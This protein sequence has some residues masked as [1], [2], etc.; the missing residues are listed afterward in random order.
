MKRIIFKFWLINILINIAL[1]ITYRIVISET[2]HADGNFL[3]TLLQILDIVLNLAYSFIYLIAITF[4]SFAL[5][6]NLIDKIRNNLYLS[7]LTFLGI[8]LFCVIFIISKILTDG[9]PIDNNVTVF[10]NLLI[11]SIIYLL[12]TTLE[13]LLF[14]KKL[15]KSGLNE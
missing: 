3:E 13:I 6:L 14:R 4:C 5:F 11:F 10:R 7:L 15:K 2:N 12:F 1:F 8:P 9:L